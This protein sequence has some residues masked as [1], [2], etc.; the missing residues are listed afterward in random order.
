MAV[1][2][3]HLVERLRVR[4]FVDEP[5][6]GRVQEGQPVTIGW[7]ALPGRAWQGLSLIHI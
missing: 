5:E 7:D 3:T 6:L 1:S 2:Y 4:V